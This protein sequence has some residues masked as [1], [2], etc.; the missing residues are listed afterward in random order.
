MIGAPVGFQCPQCVAE[1]AR[2]IP[3]T[4]TAVGGRVVAGTGTQLTM[5]LIGLNGLVW[6]AAVVGGFPFVA[7]WGMF[8]PAVADGEWWRLLT[9]SFLHRE[10]WHIGVNMYA[11]WI[12]GGLLEPLLGRGRYLALYLVSAVGGTAASYAFSEP[13]VLSYGA[14]GAVFGL[15]G[16]AYVVMRRLRRDVTGVTVVLLLSVVLG[17]V[18]QG[19]DWRAHLGGLASG[20]A[21]A[22]AFAYAPR[23]RRTEAAWAAGVALLVLI[24][25]LVAWRT[26]T[27]T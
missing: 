12:L 14:S 21:L 26:A 1:G 20:A 23:A 19:I 13:L 24:G 10:V 15:F 3:A 18:V 5:G 17:F 11:L 22:A 9:A 6:L 2:S 8:P 25:L 4:R 7:R 27:L 16:A